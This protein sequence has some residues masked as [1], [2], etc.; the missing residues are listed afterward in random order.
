M[1]SMPGMTVVE[2]SCEDEVLALLRWAIN[3]N[4][5]SSYVRLMSLPVAVNFT[6]PADYVAEIGVGVEL[7]PGTDALIFAYGPQMLT[8]A[9]EAALFIESQQD[10]S[11]GVI[12]M[13]WLN[14]VDA[15]WFRGKAGVVKNIF[16]VDNHYSIGGLGDRIGRLL[17]SNPD[18][19]AKLTH[20]GLDDTPS[21]GT[22]DEVMSFHGLDVKGI[23]GALEKTLF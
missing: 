9:I 15:D 20:I 13:P 6:L 10:I 18:I 4:P 11:V 5:G 7:K 3:E 22:N 8:N 14:E 2:P 1:G 12:N 16:V 19:E 21:C 17:A 23:A